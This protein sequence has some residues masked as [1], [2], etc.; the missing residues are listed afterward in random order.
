ML[1]IL[2]VALMVVG[3]L[4]VLA[5]A[6]GPTALAAPSPPT[7]AAS[8]FTH[9]DLLVT[10]GEQF[11]IQPTP[12]T[13]TYFQGGNITVERGGTLIVRNVTLSFV[14]FVSSTGTP[15]QRLSHIFRFIDNGT[16]N[17]YTPP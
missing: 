17:L 2:L 8:P 11:V 7:A 13:H 10:P 3:G 14:Q 9:G 15:M 12:G 6:H 1:S 5:T 4:S 16:V